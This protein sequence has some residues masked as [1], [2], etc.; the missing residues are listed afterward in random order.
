MKIMMRMMTRMLM[1]MMMVIT[2]M[3]ARTLLE[4]PL[5]F[6]GN[7]IHLISR[8]QTMDLSKRRSPNKRR[9]APKGMLLDK[10]RIAG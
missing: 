10:R 1:M 8:L 3:I 6:L 2:R 9:R 4:P 7:L 5:T